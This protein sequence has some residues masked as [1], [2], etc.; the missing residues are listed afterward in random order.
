MLIRTKPSRKNNAVTAYSESIWVERVIAQQ[1]HL[2]YF[3]ASYKNC[4][5]IVNVNSHQTFKE[6]QWK[7]GY[8]NQMWYKWGRE[9]KG[10]KVYKDN[11][12]EE[13]VRTKLKENIDVRS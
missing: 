2:F 3:N 8:Y 12:R 5:V 4:Y 11:A 1:Q 9:E 6:K 13:S 7:N 10:K